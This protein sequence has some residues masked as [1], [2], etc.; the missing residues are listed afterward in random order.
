MI[1]TPLPEEFTERMKKQLGA[2][3]PAF[4]NALLNEEKTKGLRVNRHKIGV[5]DYLRITPYELERIPYTSD[6]FYFPGNIQMGSDPGRHAGMFYMQDPSA[7]IPVN[8]LDV[9]PGWKVLDLCAAPG[10]KTSQLSD[11]VGADGLVVAN[12]IRIGRINRLLEVVEKLGLENVLVT[13]TTV[14]KLCSNFS[15]FFDMVLLDA[16]CSCEGMFRKKSKDIGYWSPEKVKEC[17]DI[18]KSLLNDA[19]P[20]VIPGGFIVYSTCTFSIDENEMVIKSFLEDHPDYELVDVNERLIE[21]TLPGINISDS[22]PFE[23]TRRFYPHISRGEG[24]F[25]AVLRRCDS[26]SDS[27]LPDNT[28]PKMQDPESIKTISEFLKEAGISIEKD[29]IHIHENEIWILPKNTLFI[30]DITI[31]NGILLGHFEND[32]IIPAH[33]FFS[34]FGS[35][36]KNRLELSEN[37]AMLSRYLKG[38]ALDTELPKG[39]GAATVCDCALGGFL[40]SDE[41]FIN[42]YPEALRNWSDISVSFRLSSS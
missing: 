28:N 39:Y 27:S 21:Y 26:K 3:Y 30:K 14:N 35:L 16:P 17:S 11:A 19:A 23:K 25:V 6:G 42:L 32:R 40:I 2:E 29:R 41:N 31:R 13:M 24:Q 15:N 18:Q 22:I 1:S 9:K 38:E 34:S 12:D 8:A 33:S 10:G 20:V 37:E 7:M 4:E 5:D 36:I